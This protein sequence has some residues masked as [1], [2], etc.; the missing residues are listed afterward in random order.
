[1]KKLALIAL[2]GISGIA[3]AAYV[4]IDAGPERRDIIA[5]D[6]VMLGTNITTRPEVPDTMVSQEPVV[7]PADN[8]YYYTSYGN[9][10]VA[11]TVAGA[12]A[13]AAD[14]VED[15]GQVA[16]SVIPF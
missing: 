3:N 16:A 10:P 2:L 4:A 8:R 1:M 7:T 14:A 6:P 9:R 15:A 13:V 5:Q 12:T 11:N